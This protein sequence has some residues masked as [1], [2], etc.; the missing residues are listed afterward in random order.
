MPGEVAAINNCTSILTDPAGM[1]KLSGPDAL[2]AFSDLSLYTTAEAC[3][4]VRW[5]L[6]FPYPHRVTYS[7]WHGVWDAVSLATDG[8][9]V[10]VRN[11]VRRIPRVHLLDAHPRTEQSTR[12]WMAT[13]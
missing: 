4:M 3:P 8:V 7:A 13:D 11:P 9:L 6:P 12:A 2:K 10:L 5:Q 1:Y